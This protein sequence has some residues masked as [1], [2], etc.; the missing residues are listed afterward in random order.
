MIVYLLLIFLDKASKNSQCRP[1]MPLKMR[2]CIFTLPAALR[3]NVIAVV[4]ALEINLLLQWCVRHLRNSYPFS[5]YIKY[6]Y[7]WSHMSL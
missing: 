2:L 6:R 1:K 7:F 5:K 3:P 4:T